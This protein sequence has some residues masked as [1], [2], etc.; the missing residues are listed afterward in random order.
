VLSHTVLQDSEKVIGFL[1]ISKY[2][3]WLIKESNKILKITLFKIHFLFKIVL[4]DL[5]LDL[6]V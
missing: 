5:N 1:W 4:K 3:C 6:L 2:V